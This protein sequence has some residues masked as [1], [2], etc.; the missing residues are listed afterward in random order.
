MCAAAS[1][2]VNLQAGL[3]LA[4]PRVPAALPPIRFV[5]AGVIAGTQCDD[6]RPHPLGRLSPRT[7]P[8]RSTESGDGPLALGGEHAD[9]A[10]P[11]WVTLWWVRFSGR[12]SDAWFAQ[13]LITSMP[14]RQLGSAA[15]RTIPCTAVRRPGRVS[16][17]QI[18]FGAVET[19]VRPSR[20]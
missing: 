13:G 3:R 20:V 16:R 5:Q 4:P 9:P 10:R 15:H 19:R 18:A 8:G 12:I 14:S 2:G 7:P 11:F 1:G 17:G 6:C